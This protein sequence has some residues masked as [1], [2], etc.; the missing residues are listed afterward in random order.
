MDSLT[1]KLIKREEDDRRWLE[2]IVNGLNR[3][4][5][6]FMAQLA[7]TLQSV[8]PTPIVNPSTVP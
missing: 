8:N 1:K 2:S 6:D 3:E 7:R 5:A 4:R